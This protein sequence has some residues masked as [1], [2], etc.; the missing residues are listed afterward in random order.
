MTDHDF[1]HLAATEALLQRAAGVQ[2]RLVALAKTGTDKALREGPLTY[3]PFRAVS[4]Q[5]AYAALG[6]EIE[7]SPVGAMHLAAQRRWVA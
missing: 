1:T 3:D 7:R 5:K 6:K 2:P 4:G